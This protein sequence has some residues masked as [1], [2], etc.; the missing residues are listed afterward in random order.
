MPVVDISAAEIGI[1]SLS[2]DTKNP[3]PNIEFN[4]N[5]FRDPLGNLHLRRTCVDG[6]DPAV[7]EWIKVDPRFEPILNQC[8][9]LAKDATQG[10]TKWFS[11]GFRDHHGTWISR[12]VATLISNELATLGFKVGVLHAKGQD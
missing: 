4:L 12:A 1:Y 10:G 2:G 8:I 6:K 11:I 3:T 9:I 5:S 7:Q